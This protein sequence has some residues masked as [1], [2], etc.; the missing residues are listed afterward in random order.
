M[1]H[2]F[3]L[4]LKIKFNFISSYINKNFRA[5]KIFLMKNFKID[6]KQ[7]FCLARIFFLMPIELDLFIKKRDGKWL[8]V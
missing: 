7:E 4:K 1:F 8:I 6:L 5:I 3:V 2:L